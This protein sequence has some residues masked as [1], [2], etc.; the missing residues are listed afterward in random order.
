MH[1]SS[2]VIVRDNFGRFIAD[3][4]GAATRVVEDAIMEGEDAARDVAPERT[5][6]LKSSF[7]SAVLSRTSG[8]F[9]NTAD[10]AEFQDRGT[11]PHLIT[12]NV[13]FFWER[14]GRDWIPGENFINHPGNPATHFM[15][16]GW[17]ALKR[18]VPGL[19]RRHYG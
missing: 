4:E 18:A 13:R 16:V 11:N 19:M 1:V 5:G 6:H 12:G 15:N 2:E 8:V 3:V 9:G 7:F 17:Q 10:Y 14:E